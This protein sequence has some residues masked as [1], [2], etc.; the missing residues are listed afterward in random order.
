MFYS[1]RVGPK[2]SGPKMIEKLSGFIRDFAATTG[3]F[4]P[5]NFEIDYILPASTVS[6]FPVPVGPLKRTTSPC[7]GFAI[8]KV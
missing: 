5:Q 2:I 8:N 4:L 7:P 6:V 3:Q 1:L